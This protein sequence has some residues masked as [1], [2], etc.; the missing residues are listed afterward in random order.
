MPANQKLQSLDS[1]T[2]LN[3]RVALQYGL[4]AIKAGQAVIDLTPVKVVD[5]VAV[6]V[7]LEWQRA[8]RRAGVALRFSNVPKNL[9]SLTTL[10]GV[11]ALLHPTMSTH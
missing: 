5:S 7:L 10:Y 3:A 8:A 2:V 4:A 1:L 9:Q 6:A 11:D